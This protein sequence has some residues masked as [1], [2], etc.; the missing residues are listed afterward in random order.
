MHK[1]V[2]IIAAQKLIK[3]EATVPFFH[4]IITEILVKKLTHDQVKMYD[5]I[6]ISQVINFLF[7]IIVIEWWTAASAGICL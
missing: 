1:L 4:T 5:F 3:L 2:N 7:Y 6:A